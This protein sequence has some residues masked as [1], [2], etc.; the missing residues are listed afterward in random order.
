MLLLETRQSRAK[1]GETERVKLQNRN[2]NEPQSW[3]GAAESGDHYLWIHHT[4]SNRY[5]IIH[6]AS[7]Y[8]FFKYK[9]SSFN[10][11]LCTS[12]WVVVHFFF[13]FSIRINSDRTLTF[14]ANARNP[15]PHS[16]CWHEEEE[17]WQHVSHLREL[18]WPLL[19]YFY[20]MKLFP[21]SGSARPGESTI[22]SLSELCVWRNVSLHSTATNANPNPPVG[23]VRYLIQDQGDSTA[24]CFF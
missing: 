23:S 11:S 22:R 2:N 18:F 1:K 8:A 7:F 9:Q 17:G 15:W 6:N 4:T 24:L 21:N 13:F 5:H 19:C 10:M 16:V 14:P 20:T 3:E 12:C